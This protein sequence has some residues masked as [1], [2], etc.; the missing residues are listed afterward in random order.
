MCGG[1]AFGV[2]PLMLCFHVTKHFAYQVLT[3]PMKRPQT[4]QFLTDPMKRPQTLTLNPTVPHRSH[5]ASTHPNPH[6]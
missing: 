5:E 4:L 3:D 6:P 1:F 2:Q